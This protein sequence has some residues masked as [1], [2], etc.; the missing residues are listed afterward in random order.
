MISGQKNSSKTKLKVKEIDSEVYKE[1][2]DYCEWS[3]VK[4]HAY[5]IEESA[6]QIFKIDSDWKKY[7]KSLSE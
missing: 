2:S 3:G 1:M 7:K 5:F 4:D 6:K